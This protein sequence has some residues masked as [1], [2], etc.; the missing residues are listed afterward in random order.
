MVEQT[1]LVVG[2]GAGALDG[3]IGA[4]QARV[5]GVGD[6]GHRE[7]A[8]GALRVDAPVGV[9]RYGQFA[10]RIVFDAVGVGERG[11]GIFG[12]DDLLLVGLEQSWR[13][14][15]RNAIAVGDYAQGWCALPQAKSFNFAEKA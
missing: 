8:D 11:L 9:G 7:V 13:G 12:H 2:F 3:G 15:R 1:E 4:D 10:Q 5:L 14:N 6:A